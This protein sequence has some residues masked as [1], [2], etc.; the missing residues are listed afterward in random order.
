MKRR[1]CGTLSRNEYRSG[2]TNST[3]FLSASL[4]LSFSLSLSLSLSLFILS[5]MRVAEREE[6]R[7]LRN[8]LISPDA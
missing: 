2:G 5:A 1:E 4:S 6:S 7:A 8:T 3:L